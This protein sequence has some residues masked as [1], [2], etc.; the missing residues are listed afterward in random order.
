MKDALVCTI[1]SIIKP[2]D[3]FYRD[4]TKPFG[5]HQNCK[6]CQA[7]RVKAKRKQDMVWRQ[8]QCERSKK[9]R[10]E[11]PE[12]N[13]RSVRNATLK[14]K[15][16]IT[17]DQYVEMFNKQ[18]CQCAVCGEK[19]SKGYGKMAV[20]HDHITGKI[21]GILCQPCNTSIGKMQE[22]PVLIRKLAEY[23]EKNGDLSESYF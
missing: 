12:R 11:N 3:N 16:G 17:F 20:D 10:L 15:Y 1:C 2:M 9:W 5:Y 4:K 7:K 21:R 6:Q 13:Y 23:I 18:G 14:I 8:K 19:E 22:N